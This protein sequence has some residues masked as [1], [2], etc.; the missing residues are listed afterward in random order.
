MRTIRMVLTI[1]I[2]IEN[3]FGDLLNC[4]FVWLLVC[5]QCFLM[6]VVSQECVQGLSA[7]HHS[8]FASS[9]E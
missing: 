5:N 8:V 4:L 1:I 6:V 7:V 2:N 3:M 9:V